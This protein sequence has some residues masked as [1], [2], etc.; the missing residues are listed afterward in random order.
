M[1]GGVVPDN[2][3]AR[4]SSARYRATVESVLARAEDDSGAVLIPERRPALR[5]G[6]GY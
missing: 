5:R 1:N 6:L 3:F 4:T 2:Q